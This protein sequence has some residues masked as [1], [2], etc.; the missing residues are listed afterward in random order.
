GC[1]VTI[2]LRN[3]S[4]WGGMEAP[5]FVYDPSDSVEPVVKWLNQNELEIS[6]DQTPHIVSQVR[7][8]WGIRII[9]RVGKDYP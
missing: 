5:V 1:V 3:K 8:M 7:R 6:L 4:L 9:Y 2:K